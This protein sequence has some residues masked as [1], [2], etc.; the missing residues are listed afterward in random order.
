MAHESTA[1][2]YLT[3]VGLA[4]VCSVLV[5]SAAVGLRPQQEANRQRYINKSI[6]VVAGLYD[7]KLSVEDVFKQQIQEIVI[8]LDTGDEVPPDV[9]DPYG[10]DQIASA[11]ESDVMPIETDLAGIRRREKHSKVY[12]VKGDGDDLQQIVLPVRGKG[13]W[14]TMIGF[15]AIDAGDLNSV[16][17]ITFY[18][19]AETPGLGGEIDN[20]NWQGGWK[21]KKLYAG[22]GTVALRV[23]KGAADRG[24]PDIDYR[25]DGI[26]GATLTINGVSG[27]VQYWFGGEA[28]K[29][30]LDRLRKEKGL[31]P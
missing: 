18:D 2:A 22:D 3:T 21:G 30:Y 5:S 12:L 15:I 31:Q 4:V 17:G 25:V 23:A 13:L 26:S 11:E 19:H 29:P 28:F 8:D 16:N 10:F 6:L 24:S 1:K 14:S 9:V 7:P 27:L 20:P